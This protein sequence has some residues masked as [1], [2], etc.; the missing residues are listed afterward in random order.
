MI[1]DNQRVIKFMKLDEE[2]YEQGGD[3]R[4]ARQKNVQSAT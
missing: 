3:N 4:E 2:P 1:F